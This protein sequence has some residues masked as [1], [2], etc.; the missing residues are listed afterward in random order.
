MKKTQANLKIERRH[1][2]QCPFQEKN[3]VVAQENWTNSAITLF[4]ISPTLLD[5]NNWSQHILW[6]IVE[7]LL[8]KT[9][10]S[11]LRALHALVMRALRSLVPHVPRVLRA[12]VSHV[13]LALV[14]YVVCTLRALELHAFRAISVLMPLVLRDLCALVSH[15]RRA[16]CALCSTCSRALHAPRASCLGSF[17]C[18]C[19]PMLHV[20]FT[21]LFPN[22]EF[23]WEIC[24]S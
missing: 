10:S 4:I 18:S 19:F 23:F 3:L 24:C 14:P 12:F 7:F 1:C 22:R 8:R 5:I 16:S 9:E 11:K 13:L 2:V 15:V 17:I 6:R 20:T 21:Y